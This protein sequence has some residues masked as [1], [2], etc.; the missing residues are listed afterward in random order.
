MSTVERAR[1]AKSL[2]PLV[3]GQHL[4]QPTFHERYQAM[5]PD[6]CAELVGGVVYMPSPVRLDHGK[7]SRLIAGW[8]F[9]Y[10]R[11]T[12]GVEGAD[13]ATVKLDPHGEPQPDHFLFISPELGG[14]SSV[15]AEGYFTGPPE[16]LVE[17][18]RSSR[19][20]DLKQKKTD[21][22]RAGVREYLVVELDPNQIHWF[23]LRARRFKK[24]PCGRN[25]IY[26]SSVFPG[27]WLDA[28][29]LFGDDKQRLIEVLDLG[30]AS[31]EHAAFMAS[32]ARDPR[33]RK[34]DNP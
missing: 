22:E 5:P 16:L 2:P 9:H 21:Y 1:P 13:A 12:P 15:D 24:L 4:D 14:Q 19:S 20:Y 10:E 28:S 31:P 23:V 8:L 25:G 29:A 30:L 3:A 11:H 27:L 6:T 7:E 18:A 34:V 32:L 33:K 17:I 26:R